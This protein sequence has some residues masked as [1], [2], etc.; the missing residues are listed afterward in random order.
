MVEVP[1]IKYIQWST[2]TQNTKGKLCHNL[3]PHPDTDKCPFGHWMVLPF[4]RKIW[5]YHV[6]VPILIIHFGSWSAE[7]YYG[8]TQS[9]TALMF[10]R[11]EFFLLPMAQ[12]G[13]NRLSTFLLLRVWIQFK[14]S[15]FI[16]D[17]LIISFKLH[18]VHVQVFHLLEKSWHF[19]G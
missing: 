7:K 16:S 4:F 11:I 1:F 17:K 13:V 15:T 2:T 19:K 3:M 6:H 18:Q 5:S 9:R 8:C 10:Y 14:P 12:Y